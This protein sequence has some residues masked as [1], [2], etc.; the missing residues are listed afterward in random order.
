MSIQED[1]HR[2]LVFAMKD[3]DEEKKNTLRVAIAEMSRGKD[4]VIRDPDAIKV[5]KALIANE[6]EMGK[7]KNEK[8]IET[9]ESYLP[10]PAS[11]EEIELWIRTQIDFSKYRLP[12]QAMGEITEMFSG[13]A[14]GNQIKDILLKV[15]KEKSE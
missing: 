7:K 3:K 4:K 15:A 12:I 5:L 13:R 1:L 14:D 9:L 10:P 11:D 8:Y 2:Q 6:E